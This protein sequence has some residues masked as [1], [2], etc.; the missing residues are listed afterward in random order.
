MGDILTKKIGVSIS[1]NMSAV[2][3]ESCF[4]YPLLKTYVFQKLEELKLTQLDL[5]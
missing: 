5:V 1:K 3:K 2:S 4:Q